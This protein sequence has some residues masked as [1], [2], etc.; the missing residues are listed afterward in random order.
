[1]L[2]YI[3]VFGRQLPMY[4]LMM[5]TGAFLATLFACL[6][7]KKRKLEQLDV[8]LLAVFALL[9]GLLGAKALFVITDIPNMV[10]YFQNNGFSFMWLL[11]RIG[12]AGI[13]FYG[14]LIG[15]FLGAAIYARMF[16]LDFWRHAD[17]M[18]PFLPLA[19][20]FGRMGC[21][22]AGCCY[23]RPASPPWGV[24]FN[25]AIGAPHGVTLLPVQL[26]E[27]C[28]CFLIL[29]PLMLLY[30]RKERKPGQIVGV[31]FVCYGVFRF[32]NEYLRYDEIRGIFLGVSTSQWI[33]MALVPIGILLLTGVFA[34]RL[35][36]RRAVAEEIEE[37]SC[38][39]CADCEL[40]DT[41]PDY[42]APQRDC[43]VCTECGE[44]E[45]YKRASS[46]EPLSDEPSSD[47]PAT[48]D[49]ATD[50]PSSNEPASDEPTPAE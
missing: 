38:E 11:Q 41:C 9:F 34:N 33:S 40:K 15:G 18:I 19:H 4:G 42:V 1:M 23:G 36:G 8:L 17:A 39:D 35:T 5:L 20:G 21:F 7:A 12:S 30:S 43:A 14:G 24:Y 37:I 48:D 44:C 26:Y 13:V 16:R 46:D 32:L 45:A 49:S 2:P 50:E 27:A 6:R 25:D 31:Y 47:D 29:F 10:T 22:F 28:F 3:T